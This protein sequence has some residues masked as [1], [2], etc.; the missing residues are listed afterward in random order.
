MYNKER[1][2]NIELEKRLGLLLKELK[3]AREGIDDS[4]VKQEPTTEV[5]EES[6]TTET[7]GHQQQ[8]EPTANEENLKGKEEKSPEYTI[9]D[10]QEVKNTAEENI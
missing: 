4:P 1:E 9:L 5:K 6:K 3:K 10:G 7:N 2:K 8:Q